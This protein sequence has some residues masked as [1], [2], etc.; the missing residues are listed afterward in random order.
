MRS[1]RPERPQ[2]RTTGEARRARASSRPVH[3]FPSATQTASA[4]H[5]KAAPSPDA[6]PM[7]PRGGRDASRALCS[8]RWRRRWSPRPDPDAG[9][10]VARCGFCLPR[11]A[12]HRPM[13]HEPTCA[14]GGTWRND[15][16]QQDHPP[17]RLDSG[18]LADGGRRRRSGV[19]RTAA[20][21]SEESRVP[22]TRTAGRAIGSSGG[23][24]G[25]VPPSRSGP[26]RAGP[27]GGDLRR[28]AGRASGVVLVSSGPARPVRP[29]IA[30]RLDC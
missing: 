26:S 14:D 1:I 27:A 25:R 4:R 2:G 29:V 24:P 10:V 22:A 6:T 18:A 3:E 11:A 23:P 12:P 7:P 30:D 28:R 17:D 20:A 13:M 15:R 16:S 9:P 19:V 5:D 8:S 21:P